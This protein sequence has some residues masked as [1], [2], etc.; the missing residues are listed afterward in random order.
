MWPHDEVQAMTCKEK[1]RRAI[2]GIFWCSLSLCLCPFL[3]PKAGNAAVMARTAASAGRP[4]AGGPG[5]P[6]PPGGSLG[7]GE[8]RAARQ[9]QPACLWPLLGER[10]TL[11]PC[12]VSVPVMH[13][14]MDSQLVQGT[15]EDRNCVSPLKSTC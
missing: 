8:S 9:P 6:G 15:D 1:G 12:V 5:L 2:S 3:L 4:R 7:I 13:S 14:Q 10:L 11:L